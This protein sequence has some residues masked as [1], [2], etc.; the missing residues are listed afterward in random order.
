M[1]II[2]YVLMS[3][4]LFIFLCLQSP[5]FVLEY[6]TRHFVP[7]LHVRFHTSDPNDDAIKTYLW[8]ALHEGHNGPCLHKAV[9]IT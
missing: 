9:V 1:L 5:P 6:D 3:F 8:P 4:A 7:E 2:E